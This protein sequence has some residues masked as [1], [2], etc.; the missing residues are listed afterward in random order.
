MK[1]AKL[2]AAQ[3]IKKS[4]DLKEETAANEVKVKLAKGVLDERLSLVPKLM[5]MRYCFFV[6]DF[7]LVMSVHL[8]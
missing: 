1:I 5:M 7:V 4:E 8:L 2:D 6:A 3:L